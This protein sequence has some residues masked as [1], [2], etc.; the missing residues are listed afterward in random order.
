MGQKL[1]TPF[2]DHHA[3]IPAPIAGSSSVSEYDPLDDSLPANISVKPAS[4]SRTT[5]ADKGL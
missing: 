5:P 2:G 4:L 3:V 1:D